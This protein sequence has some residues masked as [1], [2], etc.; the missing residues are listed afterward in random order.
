MGTC[1]SESVV[2]ES[3]GIVP[4]ITKDLFEKMPNYEYEYTVKVSFLEIY[5]EDIHDL[6]G[7]DVSASLQIREENQLVKIPGL[8]E[9][10]VTSS[11]EVLYL[12]HCGSTKRSVASTARNLR[13]SC[14]HAIFTLFFVAAKDSSNG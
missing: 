1:I 6:L 10:V 12:L 3:T 2:E 7:E 5:K 4:R 11:E 14:S 8:T 9:T 13:S